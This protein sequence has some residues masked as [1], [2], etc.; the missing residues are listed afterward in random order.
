MPA[1]YNEVR[2]DPSTLTTAQLVRELASL[3]E[4]LTVR[5]DAVEKAQEAFQENLIRVPTEVDRGFARLKELHEVKFQ[6]IDKQF[7]ERDTRVEQ[8]ATLVSRAVDAALQ[9][10]KEAVG[11]QQDS[12]AL[13][14][15]KS[16]AATIKQIDSQSVTIQVATSGLDSKISDMKER[17]SRLESASIGHTEEQAR[18][19]SV[20]GT[21]QGANLNLIS[22]VAV[23]VAMVS[24]V[25]AVFAIVH[26]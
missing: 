9:A 6:G 7:Q 18:Q 17:I 2:I 15:A 12:F 25:I 8:T 1:A 5:I 3:K 19:L 16:E 21:H 20:V 13:S 26:K 23:V 4:L 14:I 22:I 10:A 11:K 24:A